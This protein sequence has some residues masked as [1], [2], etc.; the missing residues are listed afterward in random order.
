MPR[1]LSIVAV[2]STRSSVIDVFALSGRA[3]D[4]MAS[5]A[6]M[7][8]QLDIAGR[9]MLRKVCP[10]VKKD[11][12]HNSNTIRTSRDGESRCNGRPD[13]CTHTHKRG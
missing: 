12:L 1:M 9:P 10:K 2:A 11:L 7:S 6:S 4:S 5:M 8:S 13:L 3:T